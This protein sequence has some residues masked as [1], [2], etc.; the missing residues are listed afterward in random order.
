MK[1][2]GYQSGKAPI[3]IVIVF[4]C[5]VELCV[6]GELACKARGLA[7]VGVR[8]NVTTANLRCSAVDKLAWRYTIM[9]GYTYC[10][11]P[12][13]ICHRFYFRQLAASMDEPLVVIMRFRLDPLT[14]LGL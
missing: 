10:L 14:D 7:R 4:D 3:V 8:L 9:D 11:L 13:D 1:A 6:V 12:K 5:S 2:E